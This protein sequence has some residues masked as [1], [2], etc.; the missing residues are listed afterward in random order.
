MNTIRFQVDLQFFSGEKTEKATPHR[1]KKA[2]EEGQVAKSQEVPAA[3]VL[4]SLFL[5]LLF[6]GKSMGDRIYQFF[7]AFFN[8]YLLFELTEETTE[9]LMTEMVY[10]AALMVWP[11]FLIS[12][13]IAFFANYLQFGLLFTTKPLQ[14]KLDKLDPIKGAKRIFSLQALVNLIKSILKVVF[15][16]IAVWLVLWAGKEELLTLATKSVGDMLTVVGKLTL[17]MG[18]M[19]AGLLVVLSIL[20]YMYQKFQYEKQLRMSKQD[21]KDEH[22]MIEGDPQIKGKIK[23]KQ[24]EM[25]MRRM[26]QEVPNAD[27][28]ITNPTHFAVAL[29]YDGTTMQAPTVVAKGQDFVALRIKEIAE[30]HEVVTIE[31]KPLARALY[32]QVEINQQIPEELFQ[33]VA[34]ILAYVYRVKGKI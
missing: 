2:R 24:R 34:E 23:Q 16:G 33:A 30:R 10:Q 29:K 9:K 5:F 17:Q 28:V 22:K 32:A 21:I 18:F 11:I 12:M 6:M 27:V 4:F 14:L 19:V 26:M 7:Q 15:V 13:A 3:L 25:A 1:R 8:R 20:D 31:N